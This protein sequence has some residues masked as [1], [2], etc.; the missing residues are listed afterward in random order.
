L[1]GVAARPVPVLDGARV[2]LRPPAP[3]DAEVARR[4]GL[5]SDILFGFGEKLVEWRELTDDEVAE[6]L[7]SLDPSPD[8]VA[9]AVEANGAYIGGARLHSFDE[10][11]RTA[12]YAV[13]FAAPES[14]GRGLGTEVT[15][16]VCAYAFYGLGLEALTV[17]VLAYNRRAIACYERCGFTLDRRVKD[18]LE[19][20]GRLHD[21][22]VLRLDVE[23]YRRLEPTWRGG[24]ETA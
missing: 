10:P 15:R 13:G 7:R 18:A 4:I 2:R 12:A 21:D 24:G 17:L 1:S 14:L 5:H 11:R 22:L 19:L 20:N 16:L 3:P 23:R 8:E 9:W 6:F